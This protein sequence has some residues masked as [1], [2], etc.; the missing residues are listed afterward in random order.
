MWSRVDEKSN[1]TKRDENV[2]YHF[3]PEYRIRQQRWFGHYLAHARTALKYSVYLWL[4]SFHSESFEK[5]F[6][7]CRH[8]GR[9]LA[10]KGYRLNDF[11]QFCLLVPMRVALNPVR[12]SALVDERW[13]E[14]ELHVQVLPYDGGSLIRTFAGLSFDFKRVTLCHNPLFFYYLIPQPAGLC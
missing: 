9:F 8:L 6:I 11:F 3:R 12:P 10:K 4:W 1:I 2:I 5:L 7:Q 13:V 14:Q